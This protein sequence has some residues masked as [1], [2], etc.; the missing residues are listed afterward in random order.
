MLSTDVRLR[1]AAICDRIANHS[2]V[3]FEEMTWA[4]KWA[5]HN[6]VAQKMLSQA[7][8]VSAQG[9]PARGSLDE[10]LN[11]L[12]LGNPDPSSHLVGPQDPIDLAN[13]FLRDQ[14]DDWRQRD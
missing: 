5:D 3:S 6:R 10:L 8:R 1:L 7:R 14:R 9:K 12:D 11:D 4:Q 13:W 2:E